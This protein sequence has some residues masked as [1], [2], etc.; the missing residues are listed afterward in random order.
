MDVPSAAVNKASSLKTDS[1]IMVYHLPGCNGGNWTIKI[2]TGEYPDL[3]VFKHNKMNLHP[4]TCVMQHM[5]ETS[6][7]WISRDPSESSLQVF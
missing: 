3:A 6:Y 4:S 2:P 5:E 7:T 1:C